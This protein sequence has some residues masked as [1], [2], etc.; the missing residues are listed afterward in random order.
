MGAVNDILKLSDMLEFEGTET[1]GNHILNFKHLSYDFF[2]I[3]VSTTE[4]L[5]THEQNKE[6]YTQLHMCYTR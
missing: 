6:L 2:L 4:I 3:Y 1:R 5:H